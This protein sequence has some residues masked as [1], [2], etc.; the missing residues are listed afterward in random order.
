MALVLVKEDGTG[1]AGANSYAT[2]ADGNAYHAGHLYACIW[3]N[4]STAQREMALVMAT[5]LM[6]AF[7][8][9]NGVKANVSQALQW[10]RAG[11]PDPDQ[12]RG[13]WRVLVAWGAGYF[14][15]G[16]VP[17]CVVAATCETA[18]ELLLSDRTGAPMGEGLKSSSVGAGTVVFDRG[19]RPPIL[20][21][22]AIALLG[23]IGFYRGDRG[24]PITLQRA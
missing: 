12:A 18:R 5:R 16:S 15:S 20:P 11:C 2:E 23:K 9:F 7:M 13:P 6:D 24:G 8:W 17:A 19:D 3:T 21:H 4:S 1:L 14:D 10:P 22:V